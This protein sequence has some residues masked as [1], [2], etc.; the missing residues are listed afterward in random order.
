MKLRNKLT[1]I[2][3]AAML[4][5]TGAGFAAWTF[6]NDASADSAANIAIT[7]EAEDGVLEVK[8]PANL[9]IILDQAGIYYAASADAA[10]ADAITTLDL[11]YTTTA[12]PALG[13]DMGVTFSFAFGS[14]DGWTTYVDGLSNPEAKTLTMVKGANDVSFTLPSLSYTDAKPSKESEYNA[15]KTALDGK[16]IT[17][18]VTANAA[19]DDVAD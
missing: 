18:T 1:A 16:Q 10:A 12:D 14:L 6:T 7:A 15:M 2:T 8:S 9:Y 3:A 4:A 17:I 19:A 13:V 11:T 5:F